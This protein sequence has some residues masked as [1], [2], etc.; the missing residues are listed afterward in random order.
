MG[1]TRSDVTLA[2]AT[3]GGLAGAVI[4]GLG[5]GVICGTV[6][7]LG[8]TGVFSS[9]VEGVAILGVFRMEMTS[10]GLARAIWV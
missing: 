10:G 5:G 9:V 3:S 2:A 8:T 1:R 7:V 4:W 6:A